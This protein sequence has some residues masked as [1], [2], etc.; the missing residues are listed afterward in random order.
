MT[1]PSNMSS[2]CC[3]AE[4]SPSGDRA[5]QYKLGP[6]NG[7]S[8]KQSRRNFGQSSSQEP[9]EVAMETVHS[10]TPQPEPSA[11]F[12]TSKILYRKELKSGLRTGKR[13]L[14]T[15]Y[16]LIPSNACPTDVVNFLLEKWRL[17]KPNLVISI[18][19]GTSKFHMNI[20][21][22]EVFRVGI[23]KAAA[24]TGAWII[25][26]GLN[27]GIVKT[28]GEAVKDHAVAAGAGRG[29]K[30]VAA[31]ALTSLS[32]I[33]GAQSLIDGALHDRPVVYGQGSERMAQQAM[34]D[35]NHTYA[36]LITDPKTDTTTSSSSSSSSSSSHNGPDVDPMSERDQQGSEIRIRSQIEHEISTRNITHSSTNVPVIC[37]LVNGGPHHIRA[38]HNAIENR[39]PVLVLAGSKGCANVIAKA[40]RQTDEASSSLHNIMRQ[41]FGDTIPPGETVELLRK[42]NEIVKRKHLLTIFE[43][44]G[45][46][47][48]PRIDIDEAFLKALLKG[49]QG[50]GKKD[51]LHMAVVWRRVTLAQGQL[52]KQYKWKSSE[53]FE[54]LRMALVN[55][56]TDFIRLF[57]DIN[58]KLED[59]LH[60]GELRRLY[61]EVSEDTLLYKLLLKQRGQNKVPVD[62]PDVGTV[63]K[64]LTT[65]SYEPL[66][67]SDSQPIL[68]PCRE[69]FLWAV[70]QDRQETA[71]LFWDEGKA[72]IGGALVASKIMR[73][74]QKLETEP[75]RLANL[76]EHQREYEKLAVG[77]L[78]HCYREDR[79]RTSLLLIREMPEWGNVSC[80][81][82]GAA[83]HDKQFIAH[84]AV[85]NVLNDLWSGRISRQNSHWQSFFAT[86]FPLYALWGIKFVDEEK[87]RVYSVTLQTRASKTRACGRFELDSE[88]EEDGQFDRRRDS[89]LSDTGSIAFNSSSFRAHAPARNFTLLP[90]DEMFKHK[91]VNLESIM[92]H[93]EKTRVPWTK[94]LPLFFSAPA[95]NF[96]Y[97]VMSHIVFLA[98]FSYVLLV[99]FKSEVT[100]TEYVLIGW[101]GTLAIETIRQMI[102][103]GG[104]F[105]CRKFIQSWLLNYYYLVDAVCVIMF[106]AGAVLRH[107]PGMLDAAR[108]VL[109]LTLVTF[110]IRLLHIFSVNKHL[111]PKLI[112]IIKMMNDLVVFMCILMVF[113][114][115]YGIACQAVL[116]PH[117]ADTRQMLKG[118]FYR[119]Y[120]QIYGELF[121]E[122]LEG[123]NGCSNEDPTME[124]CPANTWFGTTILA[125]YLFISNVLLLNLL[126]AMLNYTFA[127]VQ[128]NTDVVWKFQRYS[129]I[130]D[131][132][133]RPILA[134]PFIIISHFFILYSFILRCWCGCCDRFALSRSLRRLLPG[135]L[136]AEI[137]TWEKI[138][139]EDYVTKRNKTKNLDL[140]DRMSATE[141]KLENLSRK[142][143]A[144][145]NNPEIGTQMKERLDNLEYQM[146]D[147]KELLHQTLKAVS[148]SGPARE[149]IHKSP[150][151]S[152]HAVTSL[153]KVELKQTKE[154]ISNEEEER[155]RIE[156][157]KQEEEDEGLLEEEQEGDE[158]ILEIDLDSIQDREL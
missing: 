97:Y 131:Y 119:S 58:V 117:V 63:I 52:L 25:S 84:P 82:L 7:Q 9:G 55:D 145:F 105:D 71:R 32:E 43:L 149:A 98:L 135:D 36:L 153:Q 65:H 45:V 139:G 140:T 107:Y 108:I 74:M 113:L 106:T 19:G 85:Q 123:R 81:C 83:A 40:L 26:S 34:L 49:S 147:M 118:I 17:P 104:F 68:N 158:S 154:D 96:R 59:Y 141:M 122:E 110:Y 35:P 99:E 138:Q 87:D 42:L 3:C 13:W 151:K 44:D 133:N 88:D 146:R 125:V 62:L 148:G 33:D 78:D 18:V 114:L 77:V 76:E 5:E 47:G 54:A 111:G 150:S 31:I 124:P 46:E 144:F 4:S 130:K 23:A 132:Y 103:I 29:R 127:S 116:F 12:Q 100:I 11:D 51:Q 48:V 137:T 109:S 129:L 95:I 50:S 152:L 37:F 57:L 39:T 24:T 53:L 90:F 73:A 102:S 56:Q 61:N 79:R 121:L 21:R 101:V 134:P 66:Y 157:G 22:R 143:T 38:I 126:I 1:S 128:E 16:A 8:T 86:F 75:Q 64:S 6:P 92:N 20:Q 67:L 112:M 156:E 60:A 2:C 70:L 136:I 80:L 28:V 15:R 30:K 69:L 120:F 10:Y 89:I 14:K 27:C 91:T 142:S 115:A 155:A 72:W 94:R 41:E 93:E